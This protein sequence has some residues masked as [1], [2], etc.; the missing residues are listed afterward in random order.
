ME[1]SSPPSVPQ[2]PRRQAT[3][4]AAAAPW[5][6]S[7]LLFAITAAALRFEGQP[8]SCASEDWSPWISDVWT[9]HCSQ[10]LFDPYSITHVSHGLIF[11]GV[12]WLV[13]RRMKMGW[14]FCIAIAIAAAWEILENS[15]FIINRYRNVTMSLEYLGDSVINALGDVASCGIGF[16]LARWMGWRWA[17]ALFVATEVLLLVL[18]KDNLT[19]NVIMLVWP[20]QAIK[21]WQMVGH[22]PG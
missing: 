15:P 3:G 5:L 12:L 4:I 9:S 6:V 20:L 11:Y 8:W 1:Q 7:G 22:A 17:L 13:A 2:D 14:R 18:I 21:D 10:H 16:V 19:L